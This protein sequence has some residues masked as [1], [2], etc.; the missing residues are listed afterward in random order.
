MCGWPGL[1]YAEEE[2]A[3]RRDKSYTLLNGVK[4]TALNADELRDALFDMVTSNTSTH[5]TVTDGD[6]TTFIRA[7]KGLQG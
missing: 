1:S 2:V 7:T 4:S 3:D 5:F 6:G